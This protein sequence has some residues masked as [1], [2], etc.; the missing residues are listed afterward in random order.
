MVRAK[1]GEQPREPSPRVPRGKSGLARGRRCKAYGISLTPEHVDR[2]DAARKKGQSRSAVLQKLIEAALPVNNDIA[3]KAAKPLNHQG[4]NR[5][6]D[7]G[8][9]T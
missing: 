1:D 5:M 2:I 6:L 9:G 7:R 3:R 4:D 8:H